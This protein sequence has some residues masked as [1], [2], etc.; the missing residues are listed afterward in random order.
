VVVTSLMQRAVDSVKAKV[1]PVKPR[2]SPCTA[3]PR[4]RILTGAAFTRLNDQ[5]AAVPRNVT[6]VVKIDRDFGLSAAMLFSS[7]NTL[8]SRGSIQAGF[9]KLP[10]TEH[11]G[12]LKPSCGQSPLPE[13]RGGHVLVGEVGD[14]GAAGAGI[15]ATHKVVSFATYK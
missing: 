11:L 9:A 8:Q 14:A 10:N 2:Q 5:Y 13:A 12:G 6:T 4:Q 15:S 7:W 3:Q 1:V